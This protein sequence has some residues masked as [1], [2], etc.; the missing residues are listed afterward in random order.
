MPNVIRRPQADE[1]VRCFEMFKRE[2]SKHE[3]PHERDD[4]SSH[5]HELDLQKDIQLLEEVKDIRDELNILH[6][7]LEDQEALLERLSTLISQPDTM[8]EQKIEKD[9][10]LNYYRERS[11][12]KLRVEKVRKLQMDA[13]TAY[14]SVSCPDTLFTQSLG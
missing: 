8:V 5:F 11:D 1:E 3:D 10:V 12:I 14:N 9:P 13:G 7:I 4:P 2:I 6:S